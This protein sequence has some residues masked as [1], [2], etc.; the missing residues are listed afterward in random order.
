MSLMSLV[1]LCIALLVAVLGYMTAWFFV[2]RLSNRT[3]VVDIAW[4][5]G[6]VYV[7]WVAWLI[8]DMPPG[9]PLLT[10]L[11][12]TA[13][14]LRLAF[15][16][17]TRNIRK[18]EDHRYVVF[19]KKW[20]PRFWET[21]YLRIFL[22]QGVLL[23]TIGSTAL[24][25]IIATTTSNLITNVGYVIWAAGITYE[26]IADYQLRKFVNRKKPGEI[27]QLGLWR[28]SRHPNY[29]GEIASWWGAAIV[30]LSLQQWWAVLGA[31]SITILITKVSGIPPLEHHYANNSQFQE[32]K[33]RTSV[34][35][36]LP[37][38]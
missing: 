8:Q 28:Y 9:V 6:F 17:G 18:P 11:F 35:I 14:G 36:P 5:L 7:A 38:R 33:K 26:T 37:R 34:L 3:D 27:M 25:S 24:A 4:G 19:R 15:H 32:Y 12:V 31:L 29:F 30:G 2:A 20:Q 10:V 16:I 1:I 21:A 23:L 13:W 22:L